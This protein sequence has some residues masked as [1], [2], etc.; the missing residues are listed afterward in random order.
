MARLAVNG[1]AGRMGR[2]LLGAI[3]EREK[4]ELAAAFERTGSSAVGADV[5]L[6][7]PGV[8]TGMQVHD[9]LAAWTREFDVLID[10][11]APEAS[12][13]ILETLA[14]TGKAVVI[15]T[16]GFT[17][18]QKQAIREAAKSN[19]IVFA[20]NFSVG[21]T[22]CVKLLELTAKVLGDDYDVEVIEAH[23]RNKV[24]SPSGT[25]LRMG[26]AVADALNRSLPDCAIYGR[27]GNTG[28]RSRN[29]IGFETIRGG[30]IIGDLTCLLYTSP[31]PRDGLLSRMTSSA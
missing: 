28:E 11:S 3:A 16:T 6:L 24:D 5:S 20:P 19:P 29:A 4:G 26:E 17:A 15:G 10:F 14:G 18:R 30:D 12:L 1:A 9:N 13:A 23:H 2:Q 25:A 22:L 7:C 31:S 8:G 21:V 27:Q